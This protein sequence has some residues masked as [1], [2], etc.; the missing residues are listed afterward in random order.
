[1]A[2][3]GHFGATMRSFILYQYY[4]ALVTEPL[5]LE[6][7]HEYGVAISSGQLHALIVEN[8]ERF[9]RETALAIAAPPL[10]EKLPSRSRI[11]YLAN[12]A[13][14]MH[15][16]GLAGVFTLFACSFVVTDG[17]SAPRMSTWRATTADTASL[18]WTRIAASWTLR[19]GHCSSKP[20]S[21]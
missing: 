15:E 8:K 21:V 3:G 19:M 2:G 12:I 13:S 17:N 1:M 5:L 11:M 20:I 7:L 10:L 9:H 4:H 16:I 18:S 14:I 6:E